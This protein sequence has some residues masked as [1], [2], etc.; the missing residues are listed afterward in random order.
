MSMQKINSCYSTVFEKLYNEISWALMGNIFIC[1]YLS[2]NLKTQAQ[3][4]KK[5]DIYNEVIINKL[6]FSYF[7]N[8]YSTVFLQLLLSRIGGTVKGSV[9][10]PVRS[11]A[12]VNTA[13]EFV[14]LDRESCPK[15]HIEFVIKED[16]NSHATDLQEHWQDL[17]PVP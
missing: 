8:F 16:T 17:T 1:R 6:L 15:M 11:G 13:N 2:Y 10:R 4:I 9:W 7:V 3:D 5:I 14:G 12:T